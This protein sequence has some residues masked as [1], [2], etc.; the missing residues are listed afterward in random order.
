MLYDFENDIDVQRFDFRINQLKEKKSKVEL[1]EKRL[2]RTLSQNSYLHV[3]IATFCIE[4]GYTLD[5]GKI[6]LK[7]QCNF[8][9]YEKKGERFLKKSSS[10][11]TKGLTDWIDWIRNYAGLQGI[12]IPT[13][14]DYQRN[15]VEIE[16]QIQEHKQYL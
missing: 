16:K 4:V 14:E 13:P 8:M 3:C 9:V 15:W 6:H 7:R 12:Y 11:N 5:E 10:M 1:T 2:N